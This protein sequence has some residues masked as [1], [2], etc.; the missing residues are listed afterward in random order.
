MD[1][2]K[3]SHEPTHALGPFQH[4]GP[5]VIDHEFRSILE[6]NTRYILKTDFV[7]VYFGNKTYSQVFSKAYTVSKCYEGE[8]GCAYVVNNVGW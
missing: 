5:A 2:D 8:Y 1:L 6:R 7:T 3:N 4:R